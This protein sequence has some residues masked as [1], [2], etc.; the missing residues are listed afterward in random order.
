VWSKF[1]D[2]TPDCPKLLKV[3]P[4]AA[5]L[6]TWSIIWSGRELTDGL[7]PRQKGLTLVC[8]ADYRTPAGRPILAEALIAELLL[9]RLWEPEGAHYRIHDYLEYQPSKAEVMA[10][11][12]KSQDQRAQAGRARAASAPRDE[13]GRYL[14][15]N[16][17]C[18]DP[19]EDDP[20]GQP[21]EDDSAGPAE[22]SDQPAECDSA[23][24]AEA[25]GE[26][27]SQPATFT[28]A[29]RSEPDPGIR[30]LVQGST[31][32]PTPTPANSSGDP[33][34]QPAGI[35]SAGPA[36]ASDNPA[37]LPGSRFPDPEPGSRD[38]QRS[39]ARR[40]SPQSRGRPRAP[41]AE[42]DR[43]P[44]V[45]EFPCDG[46]VRVWTLR[47]AY[48]AELEELFPALDILGEA[49][50]ALGWIR[51]H[52]AQRK[53]ATGMPACLLGW[54]RRS[55]NSP[56]LRSP[57]SVAKATRLQSGGSGSSQ[58]EAELE[59]LEREAANGG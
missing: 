58:G 18:I 28:S 38:P 53:T 11:R 51:T 13:S 24:P 59:E 35:A 30:G 34:G 33:A 23:G 46:P 40:Q 6:W 14:G 2:Q 12:D 19:Q 54:C 39:A 15:G 49:K 22:A 8:T 5:H 9:E 20:A 50:Q 43:S 3:S 21:A 36:G 52:P 41:A 44:P 25:S 16:G 29:N 57:E 47:Q 56:R 37:P 10:S 48:A 32:K 31:R 1:D 26:P 45:L 42:P 55:Q 27:A 4:L 7:V 17:R